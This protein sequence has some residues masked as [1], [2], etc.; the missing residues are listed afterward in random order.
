[1]KQHHPLENPSLAPYGFVFP[2][3]KERL[4]HK[5]KGHSLWI[6]EEAIIARV[7]DRFN[8]SNAPK[9]L[10]IQRIIHEILPGLASSNRLTVGDFYHDGLPYLTRD[11]LVLSSTA[12]WLGTNNG[13]CFLDTDISR[14]S[15]PGFHPEREFCMKFALEMKR[16]DKVA[17]LTHVCTARCGRIRMINPAVG[18]YIDS[19]D[20][21]ARDRAVVDG[22]MRWLGRK[23]G[24]AFNAECT[25]LKKNA[26]TAVCEREEQLWKERSQVHSPN[27]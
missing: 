2:H 8:R 12:Q 9:P 11:I 4:E 10:P 20:V 15:I 17:S 14:D 18:C 1:M 3:R 5:P 7:W 23:D 21:F 16:S 27:A 19:S 6:N 24:R 25:L 26:R 13:R 22:F